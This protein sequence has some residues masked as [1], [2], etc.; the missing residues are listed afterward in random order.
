MGHMMPALLAR[1]LNEADPTGPSALISWVGPETQWVD[2]AQSH[3]EWMVKLNAWD[4]T[5][6]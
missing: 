4:L 5:L 3:P 6:F 2:P 1:F